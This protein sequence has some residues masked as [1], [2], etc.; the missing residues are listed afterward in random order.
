MGQLV[1]CLEA[2]L[3]DRLSFFLSIRHEVQ[4]PQPRV[5]SATSRNLRNLRYLRNLA[6]SDAAPPRT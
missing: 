6:H 3:S 1:E 2:E 5:T 4:P